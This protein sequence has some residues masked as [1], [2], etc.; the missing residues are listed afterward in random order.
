MPEVHR[1]RKILAVDDKRDNLISL[2]AIVEQYLPQCEI[3][4]ARNGEEAIQ[5]AREFRPDTI[6]LDIIMPGMDGFETCKILKS[7]AITKDIPVMMLTASEMESNGVVRG[8]EYGADAFVTKPV[9]AAQLIAQIKVML[10]IKSNEERLRKRQHDMEQLVYERTK[11]LITINRDLELEIE[12]RKK[13]E[14]LLRRSEKELRNLSMHLEDELEKERTFLARE[15]H[16]EIGQ[17]VTALKIE[18]TMLKKGIS[19]S[20]ATTHERIGTMLDLT[21]NAFESIRNI[22]LH[23]RTETIEN[24]GFVPTL[25][26]YIDDYTSRTGVKC[27]YQITEE[28]S[29]MDREMATALLR[30]IRESFVNVS[31]HAAASSISLEVERKDDIWV[32]TI[33]DDGIGFSKE[34]LKEKT[35][36]GLIG[37]RERVISMEGKFEITSIPGE[38]TTLEIE[39]PAKQS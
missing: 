5:L 9:D 38:G 26:N 35:S 21:E 17:L 36:F 1:K 22:I 13:S 11:E 18:I 37:I 34:K 31:R 27:T 16:D 19:T 20:E 14:S 4:M 30:I 24:I 25:K 8:L 39:I 23:L 33:E 32:L 2:E 12:A 15:L 3:I 7:E 29:Q 6:L 10:R 28:I